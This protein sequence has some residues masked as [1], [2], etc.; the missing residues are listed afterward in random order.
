M[1]VLG[2]FDE[3]RPGGGEEGKKGKRASVVLGCSVLTQGRFSCDDLSLGDGIAGIFR[4][5]AC[6][7]VCNSLPLSASIK[8]VR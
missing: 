3:K 1:F 2:S 6:W 5:V 8:K 7:Y 4:L